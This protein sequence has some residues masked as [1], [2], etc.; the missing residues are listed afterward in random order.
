M[1][2]STSTPPTDLPEHLKPPAYSELEAIS[3]K[4]ER[5]GMQR[6]YE[7]LKAE[8]KLPRSSAPPKTRG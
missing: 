1:T 5:R 4:Y 6:V 8:G 3:D 2:S 7:E